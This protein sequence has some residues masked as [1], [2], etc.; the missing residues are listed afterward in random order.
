VLALQGD[1]TV[2]VDAAGR[3]VVP[4]LNDSHM[5]A[6]RGGLMYNLEL[7]WD[8]PDRRAGNRPSHRRRLMSENSTGSSSPPP[9]RSSSW[10]AQTAG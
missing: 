6:I 3:R 9:P 8:G 10:T 7:R 2:V 5:H 1:A 4:G